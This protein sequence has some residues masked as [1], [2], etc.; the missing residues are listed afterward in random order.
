M[1]DNRLSDQVPLVQNICDDYKYRDQYYNVS[2]M[3]QDEHSYES[4]YLIYLNATSH[5]TED[6]DG[7]ALGSCG[8]NGTQSHKLNKKYKK[9]CQWKSVTEHPSTFNKPTKDNIELNM[10]QST[11]CNSDEIVPIK[12]LSPRTQTEEYSQPVVPHS[13]TITPSNAVSNEHTVEEGENGCPAWTGEEIQLED[14]LEQETENTTEIIEGMA[15]TQPKCKITNSIFKYL[16]ELY[17]MIEKPILYIVIILLIVE[18]L[19]RRKMK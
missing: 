3:K 5:K 9:Q 11:E 10:T 8:I 6:D 17:S 13:S 7:C 16:F 4:S 19:E 18:L 15:T 12:H 1:S 2:N 14:E